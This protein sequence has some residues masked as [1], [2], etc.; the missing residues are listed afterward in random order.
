MWSIVGDIFA[1][2][3]GFAAAGG[4][5]YVFDRTLGI[6]IYRW[7]YNLRHEVPLS[8]DIEKGALGI[9]NHRTRAQSGAAF[10]FSFLMTMR[11]KGQR[12]ARVYEGFT[13]I[14]DGCGPFWTTPR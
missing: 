4:I 6:G 5:V 2:F 8:S 11:W 12:L 10:A 13:T 3:C 1:T 14:N 7:W 9:Y